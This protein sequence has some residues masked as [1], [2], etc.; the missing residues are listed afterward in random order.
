MLDD[1]NEEFDSN[2][3]AD[4]NISE[5]TG[6]MWFA[7]QSSPLRKSK[8]YP[9]YDV[10]N[11][12]AF[13]SDEAETATNKDLCGKKSTGS[14][15]NQTHGIFVGCC[16]HGVCYGMHLMKDAEGRKDLFWVLYRYWPKEA[17]DDAIIIYDFMCSGKNG[18][19]TH[20]LQKLMT[21]SLLNRIGIYVK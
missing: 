8:W 3:P 4:V 17:L 7:W 6:D 5:E 12:F 21:S 20:F 1:V 9:K 14:G 16:M 2:V 10:P 13:E 11:S 19:I 18:P 15:R